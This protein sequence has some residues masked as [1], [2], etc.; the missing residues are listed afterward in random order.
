MRSLKSQGWIRSGQEAI[1]ICSVAD[2]EMP[3]VGEQIEIGSEIFTVRAVRSID[4]HGTFA[5]TVDRRP[6]LAS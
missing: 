5:I 4:T 3:K 2:A 1:S 6:G